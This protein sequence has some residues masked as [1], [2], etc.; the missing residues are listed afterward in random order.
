[1]VG[2]TGQK[3][4][5]FL[6]LDAIWEKNFGDGKQ[7]YYTKMRENTKMNVGGGGVQKVFVSLHE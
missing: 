4:R 2:W 3:I 7:L 5:P 1:M 6:H